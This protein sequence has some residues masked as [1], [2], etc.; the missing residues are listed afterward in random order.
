MYEKKRTEKRL[1]VPLNYETDK[2]IL[3]WIRDLGSGYSKT[4]K[5][6]TFSLYVKDLIR[7][8]IQKARKR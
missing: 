8:D 2:D 7:A 4:G 3:V 6:Y 5:S 1:V